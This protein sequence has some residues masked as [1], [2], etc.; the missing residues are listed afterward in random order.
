M[1]EVMPPAVVA[2]AV[3]TTAVRSAGMEERPMVVRTIVLAF[4]ADPVVRWC[5]PEEH[6]YLESMPALT[7]AFAGG[8][9]RDGSAYTTDGYG[10]AALLRHALDR[11]DREDLPAYLESTNSRNISLYLRHGFVA[12]GE[13]RAGSSPIVV[14]MLRLP[15]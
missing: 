6:Q 10:G 4:A 2:T 12:V 5:W 11:C 1:P 13:I 3:E 8:G 14:P 15:R 7:V 9:F